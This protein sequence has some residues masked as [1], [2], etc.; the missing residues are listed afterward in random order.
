MNFLCCCPQCYPLVMAGNKMKNK[1]MYRSSNPLAQDTDDSQ[2]VES[3]MDRIVLPMGTDAYFNGL[4]LFF[5]EEFPELL[6]KSQTIE[7]PDFHYTIMNINNVIQKNIPCVGKIVL[8]ASLAP[9]TCGLSAIPLMNA[10]PV[11]EEKLRLFLKSQNESVYDQ[12]YG[13]GNVKWELHTRLLGSHAPCSWIEI[14]ID[15]DRVHDWKLTNGD[16]L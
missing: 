10:G 16:A 4:P 12:K 1:I 11:A 5:D 13:V 7:E 8:Y 6:E 2:P 9:F 15:V 14:Q 3:T